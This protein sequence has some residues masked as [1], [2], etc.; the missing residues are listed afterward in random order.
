MSVSKSSQFENLVMTL[1]RLRSEIGTN[2]SEKVSLEYNAE[3]EKY[4]GMKEGGDGGLFR[5]T[6]NTVRE[7]HFRNWKDSDFQLLLEAVKEEREISDYEWSQ[8]FAHETGAIRR[9]FAKGGRPK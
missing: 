9:L 4:R 2:K 3:I 5:Q 1:L 7:L 6:D 8:K